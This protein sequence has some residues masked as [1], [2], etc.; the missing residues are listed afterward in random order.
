MG[1]IRASRRRR[2]TK[3][4]KAKCETS[5]TAR[6]KRERDA[7]KGRPYVVEGGGEG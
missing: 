4:T 5:E 6:E 1:S 7:H 3:G 2:T